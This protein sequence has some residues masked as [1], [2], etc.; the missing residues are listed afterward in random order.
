MQSEPML[1]SAGLRLEDLWDLPLDPPDE[2]LLEGAKNDLTTVGLT[3]GA[4]IVP[5]LGS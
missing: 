4:A 3:L 2:P 1:D 5:G